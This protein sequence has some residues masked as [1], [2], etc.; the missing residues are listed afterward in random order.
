MSGL[1]PRLLQG[2]YKTHNEVDLMQLKNIKMHIEENKQMGEFD[3]ECTLSMY[4][5]KSAFSM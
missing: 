3:I 2:A 5:G 1:T 4:K